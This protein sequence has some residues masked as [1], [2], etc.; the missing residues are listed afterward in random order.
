MS[1]LDARVYRDR[2]QLGHGGSLLRALERAIDEL[3]RLRAPNDR[4]RAAVEALVS[5]GE[6]EAALADAADPLEAK[7]ARATDTLAAAAL[8]EAVDLAGCA[9]ALAHARAPRSLAIRPPTGF[10]DHAVHPRAYACANELVD[11]PEALV[12]GVRTIGTTLSAI[13]AA[14]LRARGVAARRVTVAHAAC[15]RA[16]L[17]AEAAAAIA[18]ARA[19]GA[20]VLVVDEGPNGATSGLQSTGEAVVAAGVARERVVLVGSRPFEPM[21]SVDADV[22][23]FRTAVAP[24][25]GFAP[26]RSTAW[27]APLDI[28]GGAWRYLHYASDED[29]PAVADA[30]ERRKLVAGGRLYKFEGLGSSGQAARHRASALAADGIALDACDEGDGW[31]S[32]AWGGR[33]LHP[34]DLDAQLAAH[35]ARYCARRPSLCPLVSAEADLEPVV[36]ANVERLLG[37]AAIGGTRLAALLSPGALSIERI[38]TTD[39]RLAPHEWLRL[40]DGS[41]RKTDAIT[42]GDDELFPGPTDIAW[43]LA[44]AIVEWGMDRG[45]RDYFLSAYRRASGDDPR[46]RLDGW[47][48]AYAAIRGGFTL[49]AREACDPAEAHRWDR[50]LD[51]Y[52]SVLR[53]YLEPGLRVTMAW[54]VP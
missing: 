47:L 11:T 46:A 28:S 25:A 19:S 49:F 23:R 33:P 50:E 22:R 13:T 6:L 41:V 2:K 4:R 35:I 17:G 45:V 44:G 39:S 32:Y 1:S 51:R 38:A 5:A 54:S 10:A 42:H 14:A 53:S 34:R 7:V 16:D 15:G 48:V 40:E 52:R 29:W 12:V 18:R 36:A 24:S 3:R 8:G 27:G 30:L 31:S 43:D 37:G 9:E 21:W 20:T 26:I